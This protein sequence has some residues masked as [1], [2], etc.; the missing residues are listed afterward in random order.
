MLRHSNFQFVAK[1]HPIA[2]QYAAKQVQWTWTPVTVQESEA[3]AR[4]QSLTITK[5]ILW[6]GLNATGAKTYLDSGFIQPK[7]CANL[8]PA[9]SI[10]DT[11]ADDCFLHASADRLTAVKYAFGRNGQGGGLV[12]A[13]DRDAI[14]ETYG[15]DVICEV[16]YSTGRIKYAIDEYT[17]AGFYARKD[18]ECLLQ[19]PCLTVQDG[20]ILQCLDI[21]VLKLETATTSSRSGTL[22]TDEVFLQSDPDGLKQH[23]DIAAE[24]YEGSM[25]YRAGHSVNDAKRR[26]WVLSTD[27]S[28]VQ[29]TNHGITAALAPGHD[30]LKEIHERKQADALQEAEDKLL[31]HLHKPTISDQLLWVYWHHTADA[32][33]LGNWILMQAIPHPTSGL[34]QATVHEVLATRQHAQAPAGHGGANAEGVNLGNVARLAKSKRVLYI[35]KQRPAITRLGKGGYGTWDLTTHILCPANETLNPNGEAFHLTFA[36]QQRVVMVRIQIEEQLYPQAHNSTGTRKSRH[37]VCQARHAT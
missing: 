2:S 10:R 6:I 28:C 37:A 23:N 35:D 34:R 12:L 15:A 18:F 13:L 27:G 9:E 16:S 25:A 3:Q 30:N 21:N 26:T 22:K 7:G 5:N 14:A 32:K 24:A 20:H 8:T 29:G 17:K 4:A 19:V 36:N 33:W 11:H 1:Q 31:E